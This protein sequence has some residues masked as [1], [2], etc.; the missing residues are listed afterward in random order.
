M[1]CGVTGATLMHAVALLFQTAS[2]YSKTTHGLSFHKT[3]DA[4]R[5]FERDFSDLWHLRNKPSEYWR[6]KAMFIGLARRLDAFAG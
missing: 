1:I 6:L 3:A 4:I 2:G 5:V